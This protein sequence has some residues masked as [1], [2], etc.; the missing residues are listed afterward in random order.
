MSQKHQDELNEMKRNLKAEAE[1]IKEKSLS[2]ERE[3]VE[4][5]YNIFG[6]AVIITVHP[7]CE[8]TWVYIFVLSCE[9]SPIWMIYSIW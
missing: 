5:R 3:R 9:E 8:S 4:S 7:F 2:L 6:R 1:E